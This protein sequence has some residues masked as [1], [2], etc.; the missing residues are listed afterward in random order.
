MHRIL[1]RFLSGFNVIDPAFCGNPFSSLFCLMQFNSGQVLIDPFVD[2]NF[3][4]VVLSDCNSMIV[5]FQ[6]QRNLGDYY[7]WA[8]INRVCPF[9]SSHFFLSHF[10]ERGF[11][12]FDN[13]VDCNPF[14]SLFCLINVSFQ[15]QRKSCHFYIWV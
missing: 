14:S 3:S 7:T 10:H 11:C 6:M 5:S 8:R 15:M 1:G 9:E 4:S 12:F 2:G 13:L